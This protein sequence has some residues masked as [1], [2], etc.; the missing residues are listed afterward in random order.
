[1]FLHAVQ[2]NTEKPMQVYTD[3]HPEKRDWKSH[4][5]SILEQGGEHDMG[6][7][8]RIIMD[9]TRGQRNRHPV[10]IRNICTYTT[11]YFLNLMRCILGCFLNRI[12][13]VHVHVIRIYLAK[14]IHRR[15]Y[16]SISLY[17]KKF[18]RS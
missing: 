8:K 6:S 12:E 11:N 9:W 2:E 13:G 18:V 1:M 10:R 3:L 17:I 14:E 16:L 7:Y 4:L 15:A 5:L